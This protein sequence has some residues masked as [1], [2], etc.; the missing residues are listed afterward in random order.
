MR[1]LIAVTLAV[2]AMILSGCVDGGASTKAGGDAEPVAL[3]IGTA[4]GPGTPAADQI[5]EFVRQV[6]D[7]SGGLLQVEPMWEAAGPDQDDW[8][9]QVA[10]LVVSGDVD[11]GMIPAR[12]W[13]TEGVTTM[14]ALHAPLLVAA[15]DLLD[16]V[17][18]DGIAEEMLAGLDAI[19][20]TGLALVPE[21]LRHVFSFGDPCCHLRTS[22][23]RR[24]G[25][26]RRR[27]RTR[28]SRHSAPDPTTSVGRL[29][30][31]SPT[32]SESPTDRS[33]PRSCRSR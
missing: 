22:L 7:L 27:P 29:R 5:D 4:D 26:R 18:T 2:G 30:L 33:P 19:G 14:R 21:G 17:V 23:E 13:D 31:A 20:V 16:R 1:K 3:R 8:D 28:C 6:D 9:Q 25:H 15:D 11:L 12:A 24:S 10:R 32:R